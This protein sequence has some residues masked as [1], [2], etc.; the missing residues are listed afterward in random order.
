MIDVPGKAY[1]AVLMRRTAGISASV[2]AAG[3]HRIRRHRGQGRARR[4]RSPTSSRSPSTDH[5]AAGRAEGLGGLARSTLVILVSAFSAEYVQTWTLQLTGQRIMFDLRM[6]IYGHLQRLDLALLRS[7]PGR[8]ADDAGHVGRRRHER[9][10]HLGR[11]DDLR[12]RLHARR[13]SWS[14]CCGMNWRLALV[15]FI[16]AAAHRAW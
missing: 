9:S 11:R 7:Q 15:A 12:R 3:G 6:A 16:G 1:D 4:W 13:A 10:L 5:I 14:S 2:L 8:P